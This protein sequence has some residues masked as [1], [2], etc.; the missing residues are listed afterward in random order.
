V[1][2]I[3]SV[4]RRETPISLLRPQKEDVMLSISTLKSNFRRW[5]RI[6]NTIRELSSLSDRDLNDLGISRSDIRFVAKRSVSR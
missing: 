6:R 4:R 1:Q 3:Q 2:Q 5:A